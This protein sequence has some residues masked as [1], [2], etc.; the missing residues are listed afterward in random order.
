MIFIFLSIY[1]LIFSSSAA[2]TPVTASASSGK[3]GGMIDLQGLSTFVKYG[4][5][6]L[7][8]FIPRKLLDLA[9]KVGK[10]AN[11]LPVKIL[12]SAKNST[13]MRTLL[14][15]TYQMISNDLIEAHKQYRIKEHKFEKDR[16]I[17]G[18]LSEQKQQ[19]LENNKKLYEK[20]LSVITTLS[21]CTGENIPELKVRRL[22]RFCAFL[23]FLIVPS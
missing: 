1:K 14:L 15:D 17:H 20:L 11:E 19:E 22:I 6:I 23:M 12:A 8:G 3:G 5:E 21:E 9:K 7:F 16:L 10:P 2:A 13:E 4:S 18:S